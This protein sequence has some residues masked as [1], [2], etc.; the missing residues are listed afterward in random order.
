MLDGNVFGH[1]LLLFCSRQGS[2]GHVEVL[3]CAQVPKKMPSGN[4][5]GIKCARSA[6]GPCPEPRP[7]AT[8]LIDANGVLR[9]PYLPSEV[10]RLLFATSFFF[11]AKLF[12]CLFYFGILSGATSFSFFSCI[13]HDARKSP[14]KPCVVT[15]ATQEEVQKILFGLESAKNSGLERSQYRNLYKFG[16]SSRI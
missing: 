10:T 11:F 5:S 7:R 13:C 6:P 15:D 2:H 9:K 12:P 16:I 4:K 14:G 3:F 1:V 8:P